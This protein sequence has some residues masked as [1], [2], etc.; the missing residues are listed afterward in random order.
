MI[1]AKTNKQNKVSK[2]WEKNFPTHSGSEQ[3]S[4]CGSVHKFRW[5]VHSHKFSAASKAKTLA[6]KKGSLHTVGQSDGAIHLAHFL[7]FLFNVI[8]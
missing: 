3:S 8:S 4:W 2:S 6:A 5:S 7:S 1:I